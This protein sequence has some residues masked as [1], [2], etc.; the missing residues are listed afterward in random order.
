MGIFFSK[1]YIT[2]NE[3][4]VATIKGGIATFRFWSLLKYIMKKISNG[5]KS[6][7]NLTKGLYMQK[8]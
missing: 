6:A 1:K 7:V 5:P 4:K 8:C 2:S 3:I